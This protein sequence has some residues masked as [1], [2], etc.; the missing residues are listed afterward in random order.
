M[1]GGAKS[2]LW[3]QIMAD[4][5]QRPVAVME[6]T[7]SACLGAAILAGAAVGLYPDIATGAAQAAKVGRRFEPD[8]GPRS[9]YA[10]AYER[11]RDAYK[12]LYGRA[13]T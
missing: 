1:G 2:P 10:D 5:L 11:Y 4:V 8:P 7:E 9:A 6:C 3:V 12:R 13:M